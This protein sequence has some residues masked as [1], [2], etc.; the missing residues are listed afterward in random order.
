[1]YN[2]EQVYNFISKCLNMIFY[3]IKG[4]DFASA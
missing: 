1:M 4:K 2:L 3:W